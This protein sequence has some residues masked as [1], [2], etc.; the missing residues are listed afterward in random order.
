MCILQIS[1]VNMVCSDLILYTASLI[2]HR[3]LLTSLCFP[4]LK[5]L[6]Q[7]SFGKLLPDYFPYVANTM[8]FSPLGVLTCLESFSFVLKDEHYLGL[9]HKLLTLHALL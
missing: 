5:Y 8:T 7:L 1:I 6:I 2:T 4:I 3:P 9:G